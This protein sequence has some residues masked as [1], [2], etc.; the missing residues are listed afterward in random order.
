MAAVELD[1]A[2]NV[3]DLGGLRIANGGKTRRGILYRGDS[4]DHISRR[5]VETLTRRLGIRAVIDLRTS[6]EANP[7]N[8]AQESVQYHRYPLIQE[9]RIGKEPFPSDDPRELAKVYFDN[10]RD[11]MNAVAEIFSLLDYYVSLNEPCVFH[12][13][14]GRDRTGVI[15]ALLLA[16]VGVCD[17]DIAR[18]YVESNR[19]AHHVTQ[20]LAENPL[21]SNGHPTRDVILLKPEVILLFLDLIRKKY[22]EPAQFLLSCGVLSQALERLRTGLAEIDSQSQSTEVFS[23]AQQ[24]RR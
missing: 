9:G 7:I 17:S 12:C 10:A 5:D 22:D 15:T 24:N 21:Y 19:H 14:A 8:W 2:Y 16:L 11:G 3:R 4:L 6:L 18:D 1:G 13:A 20:R 23:C